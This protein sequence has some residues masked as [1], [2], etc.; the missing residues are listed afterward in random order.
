MAEN[1]RITGEYRKLTA[2]MNVPLVDE[3]L[4]VWMLRKWN[5]PYDI[6]HRQLHKQNSKTQTPNIPHRYSSLTNICRINT[7]DISAQLPSSS[8]N[9]MTPDNALWRRSPLNS[10]WQTEV[11]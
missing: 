9:F 7:A 2:N 6:K 5:I 1:I 10:N 8:S 4:Y 3:N 11:N